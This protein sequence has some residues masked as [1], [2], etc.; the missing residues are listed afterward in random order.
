MALERFWVYLDNKVQGPVE[1]P[2]LRKLH[3]FNL[4]T[5][6]CQEGQ[7]AWRVADEVIEI[8]SYFS[9]PPRLSSL[10]LEPSKDA[11]TLV[12]P[13]SESLGVLPD[14]G[15]A[16][17][18]HGDEVPLAL[19]DA[20]ARAQESSVKGGEG[21]AGAPHD[22][23]PATSVKEPGGPEMLRLSCTT[24][25]YKNPRDVKVCMKC[26]AK[27]PT[28]SS[29]VEPSAGLDKPAAAASADRPAEPPLAAAGWSANTA[30]S[31]M[32]EIPVARILAILVGLSFMASLSFIFYRIG[33]K[34]PQHRVV[35]VPK[36]L[37]AKPSSVVV[38][39]ART[40]RSPARTVGVRRPA[41]SHY[42]R[43]KAA[44]LPGVAGFPKPAAA[45]E[46]AN[47]PTASPPAL[48]EAPVILENAYPLKHRNPAPVESKYAQKRRSDA[49]LWTGREED[50]IRLAQRCRIYG[51]QRT[52][53]RNVEI[54]M[55]ILRD[56]EYV[57]AF[58]S[59]RRLYLF[60]D[61]DWMAAQQNGPLYEVHLTLSGGKEADG[62]ARKPLRLGFDVDLERGTVEPGGDENIRA[63]AMHAFFDESHIAPEER[64][65]VA[66]DTEELVLAA[67]P[68][69]SPLAF[70]TVARHFVQTYSELAMGRIADA[71]G[72]DLV[73]KLLQHPPRDLRAPAPASPKAETARPAAIP[74]PIPASPKPAVVA[75]KSGPIQFSLVSLGGRE[76]AAR[77]Q[78]PSHA[79]PAKLWETVTGYE[80]LSQFVPD[81]LVSDRE[82]MDGSAVVVHTVS[83]TRLFIFIFKLNLH[84]RLTEHPQQ[85]ALEFERI[86]GDFEKLQGKIEIT[87]APA[88]SQMSVDLHLTVAPH[89]LMPDWVLRGMAKRFL[90]PALDAIRAR[91]ESELQ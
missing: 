39:P 6:V 31:S 10:A 20:A 22:Q 87:S 79:S 21:K 1:I 29:N 53:E 4:L 38:L 36:P 70:Q 56:R 68:D 32:V 81:L 40:Y 50:A 78:V 19:G 13:A 34:H 23:S 59:G 3:G 65:D 24:C 51:G 60:N 47:S 17:P 8:K 35:T 75:S 37:V 16:R 88:G 44:A 54:L 77:L 48:T 11:A 7:D 76:H 9:S 14:E 45:E 27:L 73:Q 72:L 86:A 46:R 90:V 52:V 64:K 84:L 69:A 71:Y 55:Q 85:Q 80:R 12:K 67:Q 15:L 82:G 5:Q 89:V 83:L 41:Q 43:A 18:E 74:A 58:D 28:P 30:V 25:G 49:S 91:A 42:P 33:H 63:N 57:M 26:G 61:V 2:A 62:T 66:K